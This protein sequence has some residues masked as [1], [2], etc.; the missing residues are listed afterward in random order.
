MAGGQNSFQRAWDT[1]LDTFGYAGPS[2]AS[3]TTSAMLPAAGAAALA[4]QAKARNNLIETLANPTATRGQQDAAFD[5]YHNGPGQK[6]AR[7]VS[8]W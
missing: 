7:Q 3:D 5:R 8:G 6:L 1:A 2:G 4:P